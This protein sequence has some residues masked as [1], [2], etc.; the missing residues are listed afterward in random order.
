MTKNKEAITVLLLITLL[1]VC[2]ATGVKAAS[3]PPLPLP[4]NPPLTEQ[5]K[6]DQATA[7]S[8]LN[9]VFAVDTSSYK[10]EDTIRT[11][12]P[13]GEFMTFKFRSDTSSL[14]VTTQFTNG[15]LTWCMLFP[16]KGSPA[17]IAPAS[18]DVIAT[19]K[20]ILNQL[21]TLSGKDYLA[22]IRAS[23]D[24]V[25]ALQ[26]SKT[27]VSGFTQ[28]ILV[29][30]SDITFTWEPYANGLSNSQNKLYLEFNSVHLVFFADFLGKYNV[31]TDDI[32]IS[33]EEAIKT[34]MR[35][36]SSFSW[37]VGNETISNASVLDTPVIA[38]VSMQ[39]RGNSTLYPIWN[40]WLPLDKMYPGGVTAFHV[41]IWADT[42]ELSAITPIGSFGDP[43]AVNPTATTAVKSAEESQSQ[44]V[45][46]T[47]LIIFAILA[48]I[49][50]VASYHFYRRK[51]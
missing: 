19:A 26:N 41:S 12:S 8:F 40:I 32:K 3:P 20:T 5:E 31:G 14:D 4:T 46:Y 16:I 42:S 35:Y 34:A 49:M 11:N 23:L 17:Y 1:I 6:T 44:T 7:L 39:N 47:I 25:T 2:F 29:K 50:A 45:N 21:Q 51:R 9:I 24:S 22:T 48:L 28:E 10:I 37:E 33:Q 36:A 15:E 27:T 30:G 13:T 18:S 38:N 43:N